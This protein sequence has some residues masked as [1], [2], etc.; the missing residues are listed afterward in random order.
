MYL[1]QLS[2]FVE[3]KS[4]A[5][6]APCNALAEAGVNLSS[7]S[8]ADTKDFG[9]LRVITKDTDKAVEVLRAKNFAVRLTDVIAVQIEDVPGALSKVL[10]TLEEQSLDVQYMYAAV[11]NSGK[12]VMIFRFEDGEQAVE[13]LKKADCILVDSAHFF[14]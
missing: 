2:V 8:L 9:I 14:A 6:Y 5:V 4:G 1:K 10:R 3:N 7:L 12:T 11:G 13:K